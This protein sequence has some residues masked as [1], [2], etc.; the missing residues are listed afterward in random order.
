MDGLNKVRKVWVRTLQNECPTI[1]QRGGQGRLKGG[2]T[3][4]M[5]PWTCKGGHCPPLANENKKKH[6]SKDR[7]KIKEN[8]KTCALKKVYIKKEHDKSKTREAKKLVHLL[9][10][11]LITSNEAERSFSKLKLLLASTR[12][13]MGEAWLNNLALWELIR[14]ISSRFQLN[15]SFKNSKRANAKEYS[16]WQQGQLYFIF[17]W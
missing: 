1:Q 2:A 3:G 7:M 11:Y 4:A 15:P 13:A 12:S 14:A 10:T 6:I 9:L 5:H 17:W 16:I 8:L